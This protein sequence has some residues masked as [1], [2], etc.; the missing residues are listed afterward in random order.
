M[1]TPITIRYE[2]FRVKLEELINDSCLPPFII[3]LV[4]KEYLVDVHGCVVAQYQKDKS[5]YNMSIQKSMN[6]C[7]SNDN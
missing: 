2:E 3:E 4:M 6:G 1:E 5:M 7:G